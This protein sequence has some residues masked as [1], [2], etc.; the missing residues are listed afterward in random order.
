MRSNTRSFR[1][2]QTA[3]LGA[4]AVVALNVPVSAFANPTAF[5]GTIGGEK[6]VVE[7]TDDPL[8]GTARVEGRF[9]FADDGSD[10]P[11]LFDRRAAATLV[12]TQEGPCKDGECADTGPVVGAVWTL[13][14]GDGQGLAGQWRK[15][16]DIRKIVLRPLGQRPRG[17]F[18]EA[19]AHGLAG[20]SEAVSMSDEAIGPDTHPY[21]FAKLNIPLVVQ[22]KVEFNGS[23]VSY[24]VDPRTTFISPRIDGLA[25]GSS[26]AHI[27]EFLKQD[28][29]RK[30]L[31]A[32]G[33]R[34]LRYRTFRGQDGGWTSDAGSLGGYDDTT[35]RVTFLNTR[36]LSYVESGSLWCSGASPTNFIKPVTVDVRRGA[37]ISPAAL[38]AEWTDAGP[39]ERLS[40]LVQSRAKD[41]P[42]MED[43]D[44]SVERLGSY[45]TAY[46]VPGT[47]RRPEV[48][49]GIYNLPTVTAACS[50]DLA[51]ISIDEIR[52]Y[53]TP[54]GTELLM[55]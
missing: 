28:H 20:A 4:M 43:G 36:V 44:C 46:L 45:L 27:N 5:E 48:T 25:N 39:G 53:L 55:K 14:R 34:A 42:G 2:R 26:P 38:F 33:C 47:G 54:E 35:V 10:I 51:T 37:A 50:R 7:F 40:A 1:P 6:V 29:W 30:N 32:L 9:N 11:L 24:R 16:G 21:E 12:L 19:T 15:D 3:L 31:A 17:A 49:F 8:G 23:T 13:E 52:E 41:D 22:D 18:E